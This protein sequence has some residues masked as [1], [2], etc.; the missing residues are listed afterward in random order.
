MQACQEE[1]SGLTDLVGCDRAVSQFEFNGGA[2][3]TRQLKQIIGIVD[4]VYASA[5]PCND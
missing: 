2:D 3:K 5:P 1:A 4:V